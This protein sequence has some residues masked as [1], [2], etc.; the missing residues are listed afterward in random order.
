[1][2]TRQLMHPVGCNHEAG[3]ATY[4]DLLRLGKVVARVPV[5][6][7]LANLLERD[8]LLGDDLGGVEDVDAEIKGLLLVDDLHVQLP[9]GVVALLD[10][11][12]EVLA[13]E[14]GVPASGGLGLLP[15]EAGLS[16]RGLPVELYELGLALVVDEAVSV[17]AEAVLSGG[18]CVNCYSASILHG[19]EKKG[20]QC[21]PC[22]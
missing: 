8:E 14:I 5:Q 6:P 4:H 3:S 11:V 15:N 1:M 20:G 18:M 2:K 12:P 10:G 19:E 22:A 21:S 9:L 7:H 13:V 17:D 16:K